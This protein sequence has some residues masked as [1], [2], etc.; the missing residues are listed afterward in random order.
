[1]SRYNSSTTIDP[2]G[3][4][5]DA[6][7]GPRTDNQE[8]PVKNAV[9]T[10][11][12]VYCME[13][14]VDD[15][16]RSK[17]VH[18]EHSDLS[19]NRKNKRHRKFQKSTKNEAFFGDGE[20]FTKKNGTSHSLSVDWFVCTMAA[21]TLVFLALVGYGFGSG[22]FLP[23]NTTSG[24]PSAAPSNNG[25][26]NSSSSAAS[27]ALSSLSDLTTAVDRQDYKY[28]IVTLMGL[29]VV[30]ERTSPQA[31]ALEWLA[32]EDKP[33]FDP[34]TII[35]DE[36]DHYRNLVAQRYALA[37]WYFAQ[38]GPTVWV[39]LNREVSS[40]WIKFG[41][42]IHECD[43]R[44]VDCDYDN[45]TND[46]STGAGKV[47]GLRLSPALGVVL[48]GSSLS[49]ELGLLTALRRID[50]SDQ[51]LRGKI[52]DE[53]S[54]L[55]NLE[56]VVLSKNQL[57]TTIPE[58][59][60]GWTN[61][62]H[63]ALD[64][65]LLY[66]TIP[67]SVG[68][69]QNLKHLDLQTNPQ[70][71]GR[72]DDILLSPDKENATAVGPKNSLEVLDLSNTDL[73]GELPPITLPSLR[74]LRLWNTRGFRGT[75]PSEIGSWSNL[76]IFSIKEAAKLEGSIPTEFGLL[77]NLRTLEIQDSNNMSGE[78]PTELGNLSSNLRV[79]NFRYT[80][81]TGVLPLEWSS[82]S[83][84][85][86]IDLM[87]N[88][89]LKGTVPPEYSSLTSLRFMDIR[90]TDLTGNVPHGVCALESLEEFL[91]DCVRQSDKTLGKIV[92]VCCVWCH[93]A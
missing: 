23:P 5:L 28:T 75:L 80:N 14:Q 78:L 76:E 8:D 74:S 30:M 56:T 58:W 77:E 57:Q 54:T 36:R 60:G 49:T 53:W 81:Q 67:A 27:S 43:W 83:G 29:A 9:V 20:G 93:R 1:M 68:T 79:I 11:R 34:T 65:N 16:E 92:C 42:G 69:L 62:E 47:V 13:A 45:E 25:G 41:A 31:R 4:C 17:R 82:L 26:D 19:K 88:D 44:G 59:I 3:E 38:G 87:Q 51:R 85:E 21:M 50:F 7:V 33:L 70:L 12:V 10:A 39:T 55:T 32:F 48:T 64:G 6:V 22:L 61:L 52:P 71:R 73:E 24:N 18:F 91:A 89:R 46:P 37:V 15:A 2:D 66:G 40:G 35:P 90:G 84:L 63:L 72:F 86:R